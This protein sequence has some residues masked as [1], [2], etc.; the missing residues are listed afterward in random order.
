M[1]GEVAELPEPLRE[2]ARERASETGQTPSEVLARAA[3]AY[4]LL[5]ASD[6]ALPETEAVVAAEIEDADDETLAAALD[7]ETLAAAID[8]GTLAAALDDETIAS[9]ID[10]ER[11]AA[12]IDER[13][14]AVVDER[15]SERPDAAGDDETLTELTEQVTTT[16]ERLSTLES[17]VDEKIEDVRS[18][19]IQV[20]R[21]ADRK[22]S[23]DH[24]HPDIAEEIETLWGEMTE[25]SET[26]ETAVAD[27]ETLETEL[28][29]MDDRLEEGFDN[30][31]EVLRRLKESATQLRDR[32]ET[33]GSVLSNQRERV[34]ALEA[35]DTRRGA[36]EDLKR[37]ANEN[38]VQK[39]KCGSCGSTVHLGLLGNPRCP[40]CE[41]PYEGIDTDTGLFRAAKIT[42][43]DRPQLEGATGESS[44]VSFDDSLGE[45]TDE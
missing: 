34:N 17:A 41:V 29:D 39:A 25:L 6:D 44:A 20:K 2:W 45:T 4:R 31:E 1:A 9:V 23:S 18:R 13:V 32:T 10:D 28:A 19:V 38:G 36:V 8:E 26:A 37:E 24:E 30:Y 35:S 27:V 12:A 14:T 15:L 22:A 3:A 16:Q 5:E 42:V 40:H 7:D 11:L 33:L 43:A 21:E